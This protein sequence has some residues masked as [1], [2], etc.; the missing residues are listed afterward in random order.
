MSSKGSAHEEHDTEVE[1]LRREFQ[2]VMQASQTS[3]MGAL[4]N[5]MAELSKR[6][7]QSGYGGAEERTA[8]GD[9]PAGARAAREGRRYGEMET[10]GL[11]EH[12]DKKTLFQSR[13]ARPAMEDWREEYTPPR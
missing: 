3:T 2:K 12:W 1:K 11:R 4:G 7:G 13:S 8:V 9:S 10:R 5:T 6:S